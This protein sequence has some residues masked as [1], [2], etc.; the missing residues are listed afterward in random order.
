M[1]ELLILG[2]IGEVGGNKILVSG[3][4]GA[5]LLDFG[6]S[7]KKKR[8]YFM[9]HGVERVSRILRSYLLT[10]VLPRLKGIYRED[11]ALGESLLESVPQIQVDG[12]VFSH[13]HLDHYGSAGFLSPSI[14]L[15]MSKSMKALIAHSIET[16]GRAGVEREVLIFR[17][18]KEEELSKR[19]DSKKNVEEVERPVIIF[20]EKQQIRGLPYNITP[21]PVDHSVPAAFGFVMEVEDMR[22]AY[23]GDLRL[24]GAVSHLT[25]KFLVEAEGTDYLIIEGTR[26]DEVSTISEKDVRIQTVRG[27]RENRDKLTAVMVSPL[28]IDRIRTMIEVADECGKIPVL[29]PKLYHL[30]QTLR[31]TETKVQLPETKNIYILLEKRS[32]IEDGYF[33]DSPHYKRWLRKLYKENDN[34]LI[35]VEE[36]K[37]KQDDCMVI[38]TGLQYII[39]LAD[40]HP[41]PGSLLIESTSEPHNEEQEIEWEKLHRWVN[42]LKMKKKRVHASGHA[43]R[44]TLTK[45]IKK[46]KPRN[47]IP[48]HTEN[49]QAYKVIGEKL[50]LRIIF[51][52]AG[53]AVKI[54]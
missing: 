11:L 31:K 44:E 15:A 26:I 49:P 34:K 10:G 12:C 16:G 48:I 3:R 43:D 40:I 17:D 51:P 45:I 33:L 9:S 46:I 32:I 42:L 5:V 47:I 22:V 25:E 6:L 23:T 2:G 52:E 8:E 21:H 27:I 50:G 38:F 1:A 35:K 37:R 39:E 24:H 36:I 4:D 30:I 29:S 53:K 13:A 14:P 18:R 20:E 7:L 41:Q 54:G 28:D 19:R